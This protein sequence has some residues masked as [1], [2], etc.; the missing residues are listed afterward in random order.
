[1]LPKMRNCIAFG[2]CIVFFYMGY[3]YRDT[4]SERV[5]YAPKDLN[6]ICEERGLNQITLTR[7]SNKTPEARKVL[8]NVTIEDTEEEEDTVVQTSVLFDIFD[9]HQNT[10]DTSECLTTKT[11]PPFVICIHPVKKDVWVSRT[12]KHGIVW[13][14]QIIKIYQHLLK[15]DPELGVIDIG[16]NIGMYTLLA[17]AMNRSVVAVEARLLHVQMIHHAIVLNKFHNRQDI[18]LLHNAVSDSHDVMSLILEKSKVDN[19]GAMKVGQHGDGDNAPGPQEENTNVQAIYM[20]DLAKVIRFP[21]AIM[22]IDIEG[23]EHK[24]IAHCDKLL[25]KIYIPFIFMEW[26]FPTKSTATQS[27]VYDVLGKNNYVAYNARNPTHVLRKE[28][29]MQWPGDVVWKHKNA[30]F[31]L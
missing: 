6:Q 9:I 25:K 19:Q 7:D 17:V 16:A 21:K 18:V 11:V 15:Q 8:Q 31:G 2:A 22:K 10:S 1:M 27:F 13:E 12:L 26:R 30:D 20:D 3:M 28:T 23:H 24:A 29:I 14:K 5:S 4:I